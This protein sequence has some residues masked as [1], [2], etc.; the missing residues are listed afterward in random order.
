M[1]QQP[2]RKAF[3]VTILL[4]V[5]TLLA[6]ISRVFDDPIERVL[7]QIGAYERQ[8]P[9]EKV[10]L[11]TDRTTYL[12]GETIWIKSYLFYGATKGAD[13]SS[14][15][16]LVDLVNPAGAKVMLDTRLSSKSGY[17]E[18]YLPLPDSLPAGRY[19]L[20]AYTSWMRNFSEEWYF[21][22][23][24]DVVQ[25]GGVAAVNRPTGSAIDQTKPDLQFLPEGGQLVV[26]IANRL[27]FKAV[28]PTGVSVD[29]AGFVL[30][31]RKDTVVGFQSQHLGMGT[32]P[33]IPEAG[34]VYT[35]FAQI[36]GTTGFA[37]YAMPTAAA[38]GHS[39]Q[40]DN[41]SNKETIRVF[42]SSTVPV[43][44]AKPEAGSASTPMLTVLAQV[45][46]QPVH[47]AKGPMSRKS[48]MVP[49][50]RAKCP[51][52]IVQITLLNP[53]GQPVCERL[54]YSERQEQLTLTVTPATPTA[55]VR[56]RVDLTVTA[57]D[58][59]GK[60][61][62]ADLS[63]AVTDAAQQP[64]A[65]PYASSLPSYLLLTS[66]LTG[67][68]EQ[69]GYYFDPKNTDRQ[70]KLDLLL[71][72]QGWRRITW[73]KV[74]VDSLPPTPYFFDPSLTLSGSVYRGT[75]RQPAPA[76]PL[77]V[78]I[79]RQDSTQDLY[80]L[81]SDEKGR[82]FL[83]NANIIDTA[84]VF[85][86]ALK[87][88]G[89]RNFT[90]SV[91]KLFTPQIRVVRPPLIPTDIAYGELAEFLKRQSEYAAIEAQI[92]R[93]REV[94]LQTVV[95]KAKREDPYASQR[96]MFSNADASLKVDDMNSAGA[97]SVF[98]ILRGRVAGV[99]VT[100]SGPNA[101]VQIRGAANF[102][103]PIAPVFMIDGM[104]VSQEAVASISPRDVAYIDVI[105]GVGAA[106]LGSQG[107][108]G[109]INIIT[110]RGGPD[111]SYVNEKVP[112]VR[113]EKVVGFA[114]KRDFYAP[115]YDKPTPE[116]KIRPDYRA[117]L[118]WAP[119]IKT[120]ATGKATVSFYTSDAK[121]SLQL[122]LEGATVSGLPGHTEAVMKVE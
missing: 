31:S 34:Q 40:V 99:Q 120:D 37:S 93:N 7:T 19:T 1:S 79:Q 57:T 49:I 21:N 104:Q 118:L 18:G 63:L 72:T 73:E 28:S 82:F 109:G 17:G 42:V 47:A 103:G 54:V 22:K 24:I 55:G 4:S 59:D 2:L 14:G 8:Y 25:A 44:A 102:S 106:L 83:G 100:G 78:L 121:T 39:L 65:R 88:N 11:H 52:G 74:L 70:A 85:V 33:F 10:Y 29:V 81:S 27:A 86:Q 41:L 67:Y 30:D 105:K 110:K 111:N 95:V 87:T 68:V 107:A 96:G 5:V 36:P 61:V 3:L 122:V 108:G 117:T 94:Q 38:T 90:I 116:E 75:S 23:P 112:G 69:P 60:P 45:N 62:L 51:E 58:A 15:A 6:A 20:R 13:S 113:V 64:K 9:H 89:S 80:S 76:I 16:I 77:T 48:F 26:G 84:T 53:A 32:F 66:D 12:P 91:D 97:V 56:K 35:A 46:G 119:R 98:D 92:R 114:P 71:L 101:S 43:E 50:P 115:R